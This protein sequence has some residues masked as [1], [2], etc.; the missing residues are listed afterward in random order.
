MLDDL[1][2]AN[3]AGKFG[4]NALMR[5]MTSAFASWWSILGIMAASVTGFNLVRKIALIGLDQV[6]RNV[7]EIYEQWVHLPIFSIFDFFDLPRPH[8][9]QIDIFLLWFLIGGIVLRSAWVQRTDA[10]RNKRHV[11]TSWGEYFDLLLEKRMTLPF[12]L[13]LFVA[14]W[15]IGVVYFLSHPHV[16]R[17]PSGSLKPSRTRDSGGAYTY[18]CDMRIVLLMQA[19]AACF[20]VGAWMVLNLLLSLYNA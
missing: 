14:L 5:S 20:C 2:T 10:I 11:N 6:V 13:F 17:L 9:W 16:L 7:F 8:S 3:A 1:Q 19:L 4:R 18:V 12:F 15:P